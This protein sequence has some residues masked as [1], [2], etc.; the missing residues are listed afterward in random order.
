MALSGPVPGTGA[1]PCSP[2]STCVLLQGRERAAGAALSQPSYCSPITATRTLWGWHL[3][4]GRQRPVRTLAGW[5]QGPL[6][7]AVLVIPDFPTESP[8]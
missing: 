8:E 5:L 3:G 4:K 6:E 7:G 2:L 1:G